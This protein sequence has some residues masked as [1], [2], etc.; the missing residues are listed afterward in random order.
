MNRVGFLVI[1]LVVFLVLE[2]YAFQSI[3]VLV[4]NLDTSIQKGIKTV[5]WL[6][7]SVVIISFLFYNFGNPDTLGKHARTFILSF[8]FLNFLGKLFISLFLLTDDIQRGIRW[9][10]AKLSNPDSEAANEGISRSEFL[11]KT[12]ILV[13]A[14]PIV[15][16]SWGIVSGAHDYRVRRIKLPIKNLPKKLD[17]LKMAQ[18]SDIHS[19]SF[20][21]KT[22]VKGGVEMLR[23]EKPDIA[24]FTGD[25]VNNKASEMSEWVNVFDKVKA[26]LGVYSTFGNHDYGDYTNWPSEAAKNKNLQ[27]LRHVH[28]MMGWNLLSN[29]HKVLEIEGEKLGIIGV[30]NWSAK[31]RFPKYGDLKQATHQMEECPVNVL[32]SH[33]PSHWQEQVLTGYPSI[34]LTLSGHTHGMQFGID[35]PGFKWSPV[36]YMY[37]EWAGLYKNQEQY[38]YVNRG[39]G[40]IGYPGRVGILPE[41]TIFELNIA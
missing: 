31:G 24:F 14:A 32:L 22:A 7:T 23:A 33:D 41:I 36:Q 27:D 39:F 20:W 35:I 21:N 37:K 3:K 9:V 19:G 15:S 18:L 38:L 13:A 30:E 25:L 8:L 16:L 10:V 4:Q 11:A 40:Y 5:Y 6:I 26:P 17:G 29:E 28:K 2:G 1:V 12:G 34:N